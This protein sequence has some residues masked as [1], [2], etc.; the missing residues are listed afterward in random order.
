MNGFDA[1]TMVDDFITPHPATY[2]LNKLESFAD[3]LK[4]HCFQA[5][6]ALGFAKVGDC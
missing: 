2:A 4:N 6:D 5:E 3:A 1:G